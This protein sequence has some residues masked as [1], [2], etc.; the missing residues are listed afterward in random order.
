MKILLIALLCV[1]S[2]VLFAFFL[3]V[4]LAL[5]GLARCAE[6]QEAASDEPACIRPPVKAI[7]IALLL[8]LSAGPTLAGETFIT[9]NLRPSVEII[10]GVI[11]T[12]DFSK[13]AQLPPDYWCP[14]PMLVLRTFVST[15]VTPSY[16]GGARVTLYTN[17]AGEIT[18]WFA[19][20]LGVHYPA[21][22]NV[23][24]NYVLGFRKP[25][26]TVELMT[27]TK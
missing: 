21:V 26:A 10:T 27:V 17:S 22:T 12:N 3:L 2:L 11:L 14:T 20:A 1:I 18:N 15:N 24:T 16:W 6:A 7:A 5:F 23:L 8:A 9:N 19:P 4:A 25:G 13:V